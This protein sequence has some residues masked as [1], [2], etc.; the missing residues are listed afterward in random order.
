MGLC[1]DAVAQLVAQL[2]GLAGNDEG[3]VRQDKCILGMV[4]Q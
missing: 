4:K 1:W 3:K 2:D